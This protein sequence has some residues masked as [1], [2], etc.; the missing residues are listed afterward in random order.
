M[1]AG[2][3]Q[4]ENDLVYITPWLFLLQHF[5]VVRGKSK[6]HCNL[7]H[8]LRQIRCFLSLKDYQHFLFLNN[9]EVAVSVAISLALDVSVAY[10]GKWS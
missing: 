5:G 10:K 8:F 4:S 3:G 9:I 6:P 1:S 2:G 7:E